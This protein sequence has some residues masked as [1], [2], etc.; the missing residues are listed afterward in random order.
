M[1]K[2]KEFFTNIFTYTPTQKYDFVLPDSQRVGEQNPGESE[3][4]SFDDITLL[5]NANKNIY[6]S[7][8]INLDYLK[9]RFNT[10]INSD[11][12][13][14]EFTLTARNRQYKAFILYIDGMV[15]TR[16]N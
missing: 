4:T 9:V 10:L 15:D 6:P 5:E 14:R 12:V 7:L 16:S 2:F 13:I 3:N 1:N 8:D 11:I